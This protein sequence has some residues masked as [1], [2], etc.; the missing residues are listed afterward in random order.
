MRHPN[1]RDVLKVNSKKT[2]TN[3]ADSVH[4]KSRESASINRE[5]RLNCNASARH[6][7][8]PDDCLQAQARVDIDDQ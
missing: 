6:R 7:K 2:G 5:N 3:M 4:T 8:R 1:A